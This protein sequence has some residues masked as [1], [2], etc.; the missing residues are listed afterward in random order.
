METRTPVIIHCSQCGIRVEKQW[1]RAGRPSYC[2]AKCAMAFQRE[3]DFYTIWYLLQLVRELWPWKPSD[4]TMEIQPYQGVKE[5]R[6][7]LKETREWLD[8]I[9]AGTKASS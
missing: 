8:A 7:V 6:R 9:L 1:K 5:L 3:R 2:S 4:V